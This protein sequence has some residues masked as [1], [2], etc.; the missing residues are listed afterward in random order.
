MTTNTHYG[1]PISLLAAYGLAVSHIYL[2][3]IF[4][5]TIKNLLCPSKGTDIQK[6]FKI[7]PSIAMFWFFISS[8]SASTDQL[9]C[10]SVPIPTISIYFGILNIASSFL[11]RL[12]MTCIFIGRLYYP[13]RGTLY[14]FHPFV[15]I[16]LCTLCIISIGLFISTFICFMFWDINDP[17]TK[18][19][20]FTASIFDIM[21]SL[22]LGSI[23]VRKLFTIIQSYVQQSM[24]EKTTNSNPNENST[25]FVKFLITILVITALTSTTLVLILAAY[26]SI[27]DLDAH[28]QATFWW[29][30]GII[31]DN[32]INVTCIYLQF[33]FSKQYYERFCKCFDNKCQQ[34]C[35]KLILVIYGTSSIE[36]E[37]SVNMDDTK[38][39]SHV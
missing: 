12:T 28:N 5:V 22:L 39:T 32:V 25:T 36:M 26:L 15:I 2:I 38:S 17:V 11:A 20:F 8:T 16:G 27:D 23:Y 6:F 29:Q 35:D 33:P 13:F 10:V 1:H 24:K 37:V 21:S 30:A 4:I 31:I 9:I 3:T 14:A 19:V 18:Y 7:T 34:L